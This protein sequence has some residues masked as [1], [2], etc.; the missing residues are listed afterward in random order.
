MTVPIAVTK[1]ILSWRQSPMAWIASLPDYD[2]IRG[3]SLDKPVPPAV[4][5]LC[6]HLLG[7][8]GG[9]VV[10]P[11]REPLGFC[12]TLT[13]YGQTTP[14]HEVALQIGQVCACH[15]NCARIW[16]ADRAKRQ[17]ITGFALSAYDRMWRQHTWVLRDDGTLIETTAK[18]DVYFGLVLDD[19]NAE[20]FARVHSPVG[21][22]QE[23]SHSV[24]RR[25]HPRKSAGT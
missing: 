19:R 6:H 23:P 22:G 11:F 5:G 17:L 2:D 14:Y 15:E 25:R 1:I 24:H 16:L 10:V 21:T 20:T 9:K 13:L 4:K 8:S 7:L 3:K 12:R 18:R